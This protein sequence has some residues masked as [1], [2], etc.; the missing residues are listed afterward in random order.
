MVTSLVRPRLVRL[1]PVAGLF[2]AWLAVSW[3][4]T[5]LSWWRVGA[6]GGLLATF[7]WGFTHPLR[8][9]PPGITCSWGPGGGMASMAHRL[10]DEA[11]EHE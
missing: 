2:V 6:V 1:L 3:W 5:G 11:Q 4:S 7:W 10:R 9:L 8:V